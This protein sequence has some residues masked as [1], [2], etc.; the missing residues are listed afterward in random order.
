MFK[1]N[2][3]KTFTKYCKLLDGS[4]EQ[5][6]TIGTFYAEYQ[7]NA[8]DDVQVNNTQSVTKSKTRKFI[9]Q[10]SQRI[11]IYNKS[12]MDVSPDT[13]LT[14]YELYPA[15]LNS[16][17]SINNTTSGI[18][19]ELLDYS[20]QTVN[21]K[22]QS[23][24][25]S[26]NT[27][28]QTSGTSK[29]DTVGSSTSQTNSYGTSVTAGF[30]G[31]MG[32][33]SV[34]SSFEHS[35]TSSQERSHTNGYES[36]RSNSN[37]NSSSTSMSMKDWGAYSLVN[38]LTKN[39]SWT[40]GQEYPWDVI[41]CRK[42]NGKTYPNPD[43]KYAYLTEI[44]IPS[45][46]SARLYDGVSLYPP[47]QLAMFGINFMMKSV[48]LVTLDDNSDD[49]LEL[50]HDILFFR[51]A[52]CLNDNITVSAYLEK[53]P[54]MLQTV[55][56][57]ALITK[58]DLPIMGLDVLGNPVKSGI[59]GFVPNKFTVNPVPGTDVAPP[60]PFKIIS[61]SNNLLIK[62]TTTYP[63]NCGLGGFSVSETALSTVF[64]VNCTSLTMSLFF[65]I[66]DNVND[67][68]LYI[69]HW[70]TGS[71]G[72]MLTFII[73]GQEDNKITKYVDAQEAEG[74]ENNL[75]SIALRNQNFSSVDYHD[76]LQLGLNLIDIKIELIG[77]DYIAGNGYAIRAVS[78]EKS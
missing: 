21:T 6:N 57:N 56:P 74:G 4:D 27:S 18:N 9:V 19:Y 16:I 14:S 23:S 71:I 32:M 59:I 28:G 51:G 77:S 62:D 65:K 61:G 42:T 43:P 67:Y 3:P 50:N 78:I 5:N 52:H 34:T 36:S 46:M 55:P 47:S 72:I 70:K 10:V 17:I 20:P 1:K 12:G 30:Q 58:I 69:K 13:N 35:E 2:D 8:Y 33:G 11:T 25:T 38:P 75:L 49:E 53:N 7:V 66:T 22:I 54:T 37:E 68:T 15:L 44:V 60:I 45:S 31:D 40:F 39:P 48:W 63:L 24:G 41:E 29:S 64:S 76:Y 26:G 73:N